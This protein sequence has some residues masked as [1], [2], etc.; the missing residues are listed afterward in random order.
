MSLK[1][2]W[3]NEAEAARMDA[4]VRSKSIKNH[5]DTMLNDLEK[6]KTVSSLELS[7]RLGRILQAASDIEASMI[8]AGDRK[9]AN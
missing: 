2:R 6:G 1:K 3:P 4:I 9:F 5:V 7:I 8:E